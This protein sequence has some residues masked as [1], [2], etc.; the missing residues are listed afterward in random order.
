MTRR[1][2]AVLVGTALALGLVAR[3]DNPIN[4]KVPD[5]KKGDRSADTALDPKSALE[6][7][8]IKQ[9]RLSRQFRDFEGA[10]LRLAQRLE[11]SSKAEDRDKA[12]VL[13]KAL[14][15]A[16]EKGVDTDFDRLVSLLKDSKAITP[17]YLE[18]AMHQNQEVAD[19][20]R[21]ILAILLTDNRDEELRKERQR[22][23]QLLR[24][25]N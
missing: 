22:V 8:A 4:L 16:G 18:K 7:A 14:D 3:A 24:R 2:L 12:V 21:T 23:E 9:E 11:T 13:R 17:E 10:L 25:L 1:V 5:A 15:K 20:I 6:E 19:D